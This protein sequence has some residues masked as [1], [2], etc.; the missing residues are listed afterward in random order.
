MPIFL[1]KQFSGIFASIICKLSAFS[2]LQSTFPIS[3]K[4]A[5]VN[6]LLKKNS[7]DPMQPS[8]YRPISKLSTI[9][10]ILERV[11]F[12]R[13]FSHVS[14]LR[15]F[16]LFNR[17][18]DFIPQRKLRFCTSLIA[19]A[20][21]VLPGLRPSWCL[22]ISAAFDTIDNF[23][24]L[25]IFEDYFYIPGIASSWFHSY[26]SDR[27]QFVKIGN[28]SSTP[29]SLRFGVSQGSVLGPILF[30]LYTSPISE[31]LQKHAFLDHQF[32]DDITLFTGA[33]YLDT[34]PKLTKISECITELIF[35][36]SNNH[37]MVNPIKSFF[38]AL[39]FF[40][41]NAISLL[42]SL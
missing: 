40:L 9:S 10:K 38:L 37:L 13:L 28:S 1:L 5:Q 36:F 3:F 18:I 26:L 19:S 7:L 4:I 14:L 23:N 24:M 8:N 39:L 12:K 16:N 27:K 35:W 30:S 25:H 6:P 33:S 41:L 32:L 20:T 21:S 2:F 22:D 15:N 17:R 11:F 42:K 29:V 34:Q 31:I